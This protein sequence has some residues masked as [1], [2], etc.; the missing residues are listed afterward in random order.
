MLPTRELAAFL[1]PDR[2]AILDLLAEHIARGLDAQRAAESVVMR[3]GREDAFVDPC[4]AVWV[5]ACAVE[6]AEFGHALAAR[7]AR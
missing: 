6:L 5:H 7:D 1:T 2:Q 3:L 4:S